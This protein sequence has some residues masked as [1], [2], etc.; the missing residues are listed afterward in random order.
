MIVRRAKTDRSSTAVGGLTV[1]AA[2]LAAATLV[3][4]PELGPALVVGP[5][6][7]AALVHRPWMAAVLAVPALF[8]SLR[9]GPTSLA[10]LALLGAAALALPALIGTPALTALQP[11]QRAL[12]VYLLL[13]I[14]TLVFNQTLEA[15]VEWFHRALL[16]SGATLVGAW[17]VLAGQVRTALRAFVAVASCVG[18]AAVVT[19][20][21]GGLQPAYPLGLHKNFAGTLLALALI[22]CLTAPRTLGLGAVSRAAF[23]TILAVGTAATQSR[24]AMLGAAIGAVL[25]LF[26]PHDGKLVSRRSR[27]LGAV[28]AVV[29][30]GFATLSVQ[31]QAQSEQA[32]TNSLGVRREVEAYT[33]ELWRGSPVVGVGIRYFNTGDFGQFGTA[34]NNAINSELAESGVLGAAGF[35]IFHSAALII[36][37]RR[38]RTEIGIAALATVSGNLVHGMVDIYWSAGVSPLPWMLTGMALAT[39]R[40]ARE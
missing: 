28:G 4:Q 23:M 37:F 5:V 1:I 26:T 2:L 36:L 38:R 12:A 29:F 11:L 34:S 17:L 19:T 6:V 30:I 40:N 10:D 31:E 8:A 15:D 21:A 33:Q 16:V 3:R 22:L 9:V 35:V 25:W 14:P 32:S 27:L 24:G 20:L 13:L 7:V 18:V 39:T